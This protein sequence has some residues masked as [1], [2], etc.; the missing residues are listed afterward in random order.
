MSSSDEQ[1]KGEHD[2]CAKRD[3]NTS[4]EVITVNDSYEESS[5]K[6]DNEMEAPSGAECLRRCKEF[7]SITG[8][9]NALAMFY[10][11]GQNWDLNVRVYFLTSKIKYC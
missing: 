6:S 3:M 11:Q 5:N 10:L 1:T 8:T 2:K 9:D 4:D 7:A